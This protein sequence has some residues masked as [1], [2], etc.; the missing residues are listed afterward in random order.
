MRNLST[1]FA[2]VSHVRCCQPLARQVRAIQALCT[3]GV[4]AY[5][6]AMPSTAASSVTARVSTSRALDN[7]LDELAQRGGAPGGGAAAGVVLAVSAALL[8]MVAAYTD[9]DDRAAECAE[10]LIGMRVNALRAVEQDG[11]RSAELGAALAEPAEATGRD[12][13]VCEAATAA[14]ASSR[15]LGEVGVALVDELRLLADIGNPHL[16]ADLAVAAGV[17]AAGIAGASVNLRADL[18]LARDHQADREGSLAAEPEL[19]AAL[20][21][22]HD[23]EAAASAIAAETSAAFPAP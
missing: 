3:A 2:G 23:A 10:R 17:L 6:L 18:Q 5:R 22:L 7:W 21:A 11:V 9:D 15:E 12:A 20:V 13:R 16:A 1:A 14:A 19:V 4:R 8:R